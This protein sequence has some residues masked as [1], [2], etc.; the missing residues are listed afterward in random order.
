MTAR[1]SA[2]FRGTWRMSTG[3]R[4]FDLFLIA[5]AVVILVWKFSS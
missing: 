1:S 3:L 4:L 5:S 2:D